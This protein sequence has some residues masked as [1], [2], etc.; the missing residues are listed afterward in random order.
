MCSDHP[1]HQLHATIKVFTTTIIDAGG[2]I[3]INMA[4]NYLTLSR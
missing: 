1:V 2:I 4:K 3:L